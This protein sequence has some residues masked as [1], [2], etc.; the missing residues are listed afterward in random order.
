MRTDTHPAS[1]DKSQTSLHGLI[2]VS[3]CCVRVA[4]APQK[5]LTYTP[6]CWWGKS[7]V[8]R[9]K[10]TGQWVPKQSQKTYTITSID[11][12]QKSNTNKKISTCIK[13]A[14]LCPVL[15]SEWH[16]PQWY[17]TVQSYLPPTADSWM[18]NDALGYLR[19]VPIDRRACWLRKGNEVVFMLKVRPLDPCVQMLGGFLP[20]LLFWTRHLGHITANIRSALA[21]FC[22]SSTLIA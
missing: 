10:S 14:C 17:V 5:M 2:L 11:V 19:Y 6:A 15:P 4:T 7:T 3:C 8:L 20:P 1:D 12:C 13:K 22:P 9:E 18:T 21:M 16:W